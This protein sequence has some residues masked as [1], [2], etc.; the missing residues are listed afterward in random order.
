MPKCDFNKVA[1]NCFS[2]SF[3]IS[4]ENLFLRRPL[5]GCFYM[6]I[7]NYLLYPHRIGNTN[8]KLPVGIISRISL[9]SSFVLVWSCTYVKPCTCKGF[10]NLFR[11]QIRLRSA[12]RRRR[13][14]SLPSPWFFLW[15]RSFL[16]FTW[17]LR[18]IWRIS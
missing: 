13:R 16:C 10:L 4:S 12:T 3:C 8:F 14:F 7:I 9:Q 6:F 18:F 2:V 15:M 11:V 1:K 17:N 5:K